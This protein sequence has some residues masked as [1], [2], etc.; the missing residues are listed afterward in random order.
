MISNPPY[1]QQQAQIKENL[2][3]EYFAEQ[4]TLIKENKRTA[5]LI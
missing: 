4:E 1:L 2:V 3:K 5:P